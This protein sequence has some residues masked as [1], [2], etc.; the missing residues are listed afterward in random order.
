MA[1][2]Q[3]TVK[4]GDTL[5]SIAKQSC[6]TLG[7]LL[8]A[9]PQFSQPGANPNLIHPGDKVTVPS[10]AFSKNLVI[11]A[12]VIPCKTA[13]ETV[14]DYVALVKKVEDANPG[15]SAEQTL[16]ALR[17]TAGHDHPRF[18]TAYGG[19]RQADALTPTGSLTRTDIDYLRSLSHHDHTTLG[20]ETGVATDATGQAVAIGHV[21]TGMSAGQHYQPAV[22]PTKDKW[23]AFGGALGV[24]TEVDNLYVTT[25]AGD[26]A[27]YAGIVAQGRPLI[28]AERDATHA[29]FTGDID[30]FVLGS[31]IQSGA[32]SLAPPAKLSDV[33]SN[34]YGCQGQSSPGNKTRFTDF[35]G[36]VNWGKLG[37]E[38][39]AAG[40]NFRYTSDMAL[41]TPRQR[42][43]AFNRFLAW[44]NTQAQAEAGKK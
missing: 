10:P 40:D 35:R 5:T 41:P 21:L 23:E 11:Q 25:I 2:T 14:C 39:E 36:T 15:W 33:L 1:S 42:R 7:E 17:R 22:L 32:T 24:G 27:Q 3:Y 20:N 29:E 18:R 9:N 30:G 34:Y 4:P 13:P 31:Q 28:E 43:D 6:L 26:I 19:I 44:F 8:E 12:G 38:I 16:N 37:S